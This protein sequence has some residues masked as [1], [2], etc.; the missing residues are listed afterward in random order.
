MAVIVI[1][2]L[3]D[4]KTAPTRILSFLFFAFFIGTVLWPD[5]IAIALP[6]LP[7]ITVRRIL[8]VPM[9]VALLICLSASSQFRRELRGVLDAAPAIWKLLLAFVLLQLLSIAIS[10]DVSLST[11]K[12]IVTQLYWTAIF[13]VGCY[14]FKTKG[15]ASL[16]AAFLCLMLIPLA[17]IGLVEW[18]N[19]RVPW[20]GRIPSFL[21]IEDENVQSILSGA[22][23]AASGIYR[24]QSTSTTSLGYAE[25]MAFTVPFLIHFVMSSYHLL[26]RIAGVI[27]LP[28]TFFMIILTDSRLGVVGFFLSF[29]IY[30]LVWAGLRWKRHR[31]SLFGPAIVLAYPVIFSAFITATF[32]IGRLRRMVWGGGEHQFSTASR[33]EQYRMGLEIL[34]SNPLGHGI[35]LGAETLGFRNLSGA[36][37]IDTYYILI[38]LE[39]GVVG[40]LVYYAMF[41]I[42]TYKAGMS[43]F[44][45]PKSREEL[46]LIPLAIAISNFIV[47]K[48]IFS[49]DANHPIIFM[50]LAMI[51][52][53]IWRRRDHDGDVVENKPAGWAAGG[54][55]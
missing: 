11:D 38:A 34:A 22:A 43:I 15:S 47:I 19:S 33:E 5:Y 50:M 2:A 32:F 18:M 49:Q 1:W 36:L 27:A 52:A 13:F 25:Y 9:V 3:P 28:F 7:W 8:A 46:L 51:V 44:Q 29:L 14:V 53:L 54:G 12:F 35:G 40:F 48:S 20:A 42:A 4:A 39:Y 26:V 6:G 24:V 21:V 17:A 37:T 10:R 30:L 31:E 23:R 55:A 41:L 16:W 45:P